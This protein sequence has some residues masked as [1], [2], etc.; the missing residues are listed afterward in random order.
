MKPAHPFRFYALLLLV[1]LLTWVLVFAGSHFNGLYGQDAHEYL[2]YSK[3]LRLSIASGTSPGDYFWPVNYPLAGALVSFLTG[4][5]VV[6]ALQFV[7]LFT[8]IGIV[9]LLFR[10]FLQEGGQKTAAFLFTLV[11]LALSPLLLRASTLVMADMLSIFL[12]LA[13]FLLLQALLKNFRPLLFFTF[14]FCAGAAVMTRYAVA[15]LLLP[16]SL[17]LLVQLVKEKRFLFLLAALLPAAL[18]FLPHLLLRGSASGDFIGHEWIRSWSPLHFFEKNFSTPDGTMSYRL[19]NIVYSFG[20]VFSPGL[21][22]FTLPLVV[23]RLRKRQ[24]DPFQRTLAW[25]IGLYLVFLAGI[26]YQNIR[27]LLPVLPLLLLWLWPVFAEQ[28]AQRKKILLI[29][30]ALAS[31]SQVYF[32]WRAFDEV[33]IR[34]QLERNLAAMV[35]QNQGDAPVLYTF[36]VDMAL[37]SY[38]VTLPI[39]N[40]WEK[41]I[42]HFERYGLVLFNEQEFSRQW[43]GRNPMLNWEKVKTSYHLQP[44]GL[45]RHDQGWKL[46]R[47]EPL[48]P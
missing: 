4:G 7:S 29:G 1:P 11:L 32:G 38:D 34:N 31:C 27:F 33:I 35:N 30:L 41:P 46:Y 13:A 43:Q 40:M 47:I 44:I 23:M 15:V 3:A 48:L 5:N 14:V 39:V 20:M 28:Y 9:L 2:R 21:A 17:L 24:R 16:P 8:F 36:G 6:L 42:D 37:K 19:P 45:I 12:T 26:P 22:L 10:H 18:A 25:S